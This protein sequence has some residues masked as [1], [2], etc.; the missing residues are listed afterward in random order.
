MGVLASGRYGDILG[1][2]RL[3]KD[4]DV[5]PEKIDAHQLLDTA[6]SITRRLVRHSFLVCLVSSAGR[7]SDLGAVANRCTTAR[8]VEGLAVFLRQ[9][10]TNR[11][12]KASWS[13]G[14]LAPP[15]ISP[16][17]RPHVPTTQSAINL[18]ARG[19]E[20]VGFLV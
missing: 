8:R 3:P 18:P 13:F 5:S 1:G 16:F 11:V 2:A 19:G 17:C 15:S 10:K 12:A 20:F 6:K 4:Q 14:S 7:R 9:V